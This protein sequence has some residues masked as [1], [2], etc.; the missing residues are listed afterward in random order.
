MADV[1]FDDLIADVEKYIT[2]YATA[3]GQKAAELCTQKAQEAIQY[4]Y[5]DY[6]PK[7]YRRTYNLLNNSYQRYYKNNGRIVYGGVRISSDD[8]FTYPYHSWV[9]SAMVAGFSWMK[10]YHG[11]QAVHITSPTPYEKLEQ[12]IKDP[13]FIQDIMDYAEFVA[14]GGTYNVL[15]C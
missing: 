6:D 2:T 15:N 4:F 11:H 8:M 13:A 3:F 9:T 10:G 1:N 14:D 7:R 5:N 12:E